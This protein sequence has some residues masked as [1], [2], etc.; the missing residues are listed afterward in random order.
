MIADM[1]NR[2]FEK[3]LLLS[4]D[5]GWYRIGEPEGGVVKPYTNLFGE[6]MPALEKTGF[7]KNLIDLI[8]VKNPADAFML[9]V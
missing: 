4:M 1:V 9:D 5:R 8:T 3:Q 6:F 7:D 2:G